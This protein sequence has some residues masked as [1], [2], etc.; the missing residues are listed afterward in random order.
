MCHASTHDC[1]FFRVLLQQLLLC[2]YVPT[3]HFNERW[4]IN[5]NNTAQVWTQNTCS[6]NTAPSADNDKDLQL[7]HFFTV[8]IISFLRLLG[9]A[10]RLILQSYITLYFSLFLNCT[11]SRLCHCRARPG[12][13]ET[14]GEEGSGW[15]LL[16]TWQRAG[17]ICK[18]SC[19]QREEVTKPKM[20]MREQ[21]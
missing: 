9:D 6:V 2:W 1:S 7:L 16:T 15:F 19:E 18:V 14:T 21:R 5:G 4:N 3:N 20:W 11:L 13:M 17:L 8:F 12:E 10:G